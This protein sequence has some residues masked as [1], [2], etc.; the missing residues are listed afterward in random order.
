VSGKA[1]Q[2]VLSG[3][4]ITNT[5]QV[6]G[7][8]PPYTILS[9]A[10]KVAP[11]VIVQT[12]DRSFAQKDENVTDRIPE[13]QRITENT[14]IDFLPVATTT[15]SSNS[16]QTSQF[17]KVIIPSTANATTIAPKQIKLKLGPGINS[18]IFK[19]PLPTNLKIQRNINTKG[20]TVLNT[21]NPSQIVQIQS[22]APSSSI[23]N[24]QPTLTT[25]P[26][27]T[28]T[29]TAEITP[30]LV[31]V[32]S[33]ES[34]KTD[35][36]QELDDANRTKA[37]EVKHVSEASNGSAPAAKKARIEENVVQSTEEETESSSNVIYG[38]I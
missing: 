1:G 31:S 13:N 37:I 5:Y 12:I 3:K 4:G 25:T 2:L 27:V 38:K 15:S 22:S 23:A 32:A 19:G 9:S 21:L 14:P 28:Q 18:K 16:P 30:V 7:P 29:S 17:P 34:T 33:N 20:F 11:K 26:K 35:W 10:P 36:E 8:K 6:G 24:V